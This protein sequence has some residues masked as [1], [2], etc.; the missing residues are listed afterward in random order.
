MGGKGLVKMKKHMRELLRKKLP[1]K[2]TAV[3]LSLLIVMPSTGLYAFA[4]TEDESDNTTTTTTA[5]E[6]TTPDTLAAEPATG[7]QETVDESTLTTQGTDDSTASLSIVASNATVLY[8]DGYAT[9]YVAGTSES[10]I[11][12]AADAAF[13]FKVTAADGYSVDSVAVGETALTAV[14]G[15]YTIP[16]SP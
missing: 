7:G 15:V 8:G 14:D 10:P 4:Q 6:S 16:A 2:V 5:D 3:I 1:T 13:S 9:E 11:S 12:A